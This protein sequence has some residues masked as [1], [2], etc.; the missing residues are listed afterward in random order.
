MK[1]LFVSNYMNHHI[2]MVCDRL[3]QDLNGSFGFIALTPTPTERLTLGYEDMN[4]SVR[5]VTVLTAENHGNLV[6]ECVECDILLVGSAPDQWFIPRLKKGKPVVKICERFFKANDRLR[7]KIHNVVSG[8]LH[9]TRFQNKN[10]YYLCC[11]AYTKEDLSRFSRRK[12]NIYKWGYFPERSACNYETLISKKEP[13]S[14]VWAARFIDWKHPE[15]VLH[16]AKELKKASYRFSITMIGNGEMFDKV[17][18]EIDRQS[19]NE[20]ITLTGGLAPSA[21]REYMDH[22][23]VFILTS[24][25]KEGWGAVLNEA[26]SS[27]CAVVA[28]VRAGSVGYLIRNNENGFVYDGSFSQLVEKVKRL[29][30]DASLC[31]KFSKNAYETINNEWNP[32]MAAQRLIQ[33]L[34]AL[35]RGEQCDELYQT[36]PCSKG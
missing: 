2:R 15:A 19:L 22:S 30:E 25:R 6:R 35:Y 32:D 11:S 21:V 7:D 24:D 4:H 34:E 8:L 18:R 1:V 14:I 29:L 17:A 26:M 28:D 13:A 36:G 20:Y 5:Y 33:W 12:D 16:L 23:A 31:S 10:I 9:I 27:A 3:Y